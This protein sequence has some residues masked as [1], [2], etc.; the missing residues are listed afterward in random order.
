MEALPS[1]TQFV[2]HV[3]SAQIQY[4]S[5]VIYILLTLIIKA[6][7]YSW[8]KAFIIII[9]DNFC[10]ALFSGVHKLTA[11]YNIL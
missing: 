1:H 11:L 5:L 6:A 8:S 10:I 7:S 4:M 2:S 3:A 9:M